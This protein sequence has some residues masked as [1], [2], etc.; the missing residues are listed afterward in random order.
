MTDTL[1]FRVRELTVALRKLAI[2]PTMA[3]G[4]QNEVVHDGWRCR[5]CRSTFKLGEQ[6]IHSDDCPLKGTTP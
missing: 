2:I 4:R 1:M 5:V 6:E 3:D